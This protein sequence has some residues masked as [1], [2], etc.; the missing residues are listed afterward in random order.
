MPIENRDEICYKRNYLTSV[1]ARIDFPSPLK[2]V[3]KGLP[4]PM[5][6]LI[7]EMFP[8]PEPKPFVAQE[9]QF[10]NMQVKQRRV[11]EGI[12]WNFHG[13]NKEKTL[14]IGPSALFVN[15]RQYNSYQDLKNEFLRTALEFLG[16]YKGTQISRIGMRAI[17]ELKM[18][19]QKPL[20]WSEYV[21]PE[22]LHLLDFGEDTKFLSRAFHNLESNFGDFN[23]R[24]Q[25][26]MHNPDYPAKIV[27]KVF[28]LDFD[29]YYQGL[30]DRDQLTECCDRYH[31]KLQEYF[32]ASITDKLREK[33][34]A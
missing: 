33:M 4:R 1:I 24:F 13:E 28:I 11:N 16:H 14:T 27:K 22:L 32:E 20:D 23:L 10:S 8:V 21:N 26:G 30:T 29:A 19:E 6:D 2:Q 9:M 15:W 7:K 18:D 17:N 12:E 34:N 3:S 5:V 31:E 25:F